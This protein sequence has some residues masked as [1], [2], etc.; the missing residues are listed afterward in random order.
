M[1]YFG[2]IF[3]SVQIL[4]YILMILG[5]PIASLTLNG[6]YKKLPKEAKPAFISSVLIQVFALSVYLEAV[7]VFPKILP[8]FFINVLLAFFGFFIF[9]SGIKSLFS[10]SKKERI[11][12]APLSLL[13]AICFFAVLLF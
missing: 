11:V 2:I 7:E 1:I 3:F 10:E 6:K 9:F 13:T 8:D 5:V 12:I 4:L